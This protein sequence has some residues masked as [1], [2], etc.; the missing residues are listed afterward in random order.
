MQP[1]CACGSWLAGLERS[2][3]LGISIPTT[4]FPSIGISDPFS[5]KLLGFG[6]LSVEEDMRRPKEGK[7]LKVQK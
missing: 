5:V 3:N 7:G 1:S 2:R 4:R 6:A